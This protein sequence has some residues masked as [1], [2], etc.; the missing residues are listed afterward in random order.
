M[1]A[2]LARYYPGV[3]LRDLWRPGRRLTLRRL[4]V[5]LDHLPPE[6]P[7][8]TRHAPDGQ[9]AANL[10]Q[11]LIDL[12]NLLVQIHGGKEL[13]PADPRRHQQKTDLDELKA[14][15]EKYRRR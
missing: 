8:H 1:E 10:E 3:D 11:L 13:H 4:A 6:A 12:W 5:L 2:S 15:Q 7:W 9:A 14:R